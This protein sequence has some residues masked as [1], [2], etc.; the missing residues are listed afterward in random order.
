MAK[1]L[2]IVGTGL[3]AQ[4]MHAYFK[5]GGEYET[6]AFSADRSYAKATPSMLG[7]PVV[8]ILEMPSRYPAGAHEAFVAIG[9]RDLNGIRA[10]FFGQVKDMGYQCASYVHQS[11]VRWPETSYGENVFVFED[12]TVQ[13]YVSIGDDTVLWSGNHIGHHSKIGAH[14]FISS[15]V[16][17]SGNCSVGD[18]SFIGVNATVRDSVQIGARN[19]IG[20]CSLILRDTRDAQV[21]LPKGT[22]A[23]DLT[24]DRVKL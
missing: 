13:P 21:F 24:S 15:H 17:I 6:V 2:V 5:H 11:V 7:L 10:R 9:F 19:I 18:Y 12:N 14:C 8:D 1:K 3:Q 4:V 20:P 23:R 22:E 16:V